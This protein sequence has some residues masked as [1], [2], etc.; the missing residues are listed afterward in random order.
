MKT[1]MC[2]LA[3][4]L[5]FTVQAVF[6]QSLD[7]AK[8]DLYYQHYNTAKQSLTQLASSKPSGEV[9]YYLG[10][11]EIGLEDYQAAKAS[12]QKGIQTDPQSALNY[13]G[14]GRVS[15]S[16]DKDFTAAK[17]SF[18]KAWD[19]SE[20]RDFNVVRGILNATALSP[21]ADGQ[22]AIDLV[23]QF[24]DNRKNRKYE[25]TAPDYTAMGNVY[26]NLPDGGGKAATNYETAE[27]TDP[28]FAEAFYQE[29]NLW[30]R[31][32]QDSLA[33]QFWNGAISADQNYSPALYALYSYYRVRDLTKAQDYLNKYMALSDDKLNA[34]VNLVDVL[35]LQKEYQKAIDQANQLNTQPINPDTKTRLYKLIA[36]SQLA[37]GDSLDAKKNMDTYFQKQDT[38]KVLPKDY[39]F[40]ADVLKKLNE[41]SLSLVYLNKYVDKDTSTNLEFI[42]QEA[43]SLRESNDFKAADLW[44]NKLFSTA[45]TTQ[46][47]MADY[48]YRAFSKYGAATKGMGSWDDA[49]TYWKKFTTKYPDQPS[50]YYYIAQC[51]QAQ[52]TAYTGLAIDT[53]NKYISK[54]K[55]DELK[56]KADILTR[57]YS[58]MAGCYETQGDDAKALEYA[59]KLIAMDPHSAVASN[60]NSSIAYKALKAKDLDKA[61]DYAQ[62][63]LA[64][65]P[66]N[67]VAPQVLDY[68]KQMK[69]YQEKM[70]KYNEANKKKADN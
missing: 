16:S 12:F 48:Y 58:Y 18:Q 66:Q 68:V 46:L 53:Y 54:L 61:T 11:A 35:Y 14:L 43:N 22:Y 20:G 23:T 17:Q 52:D 51:Q 21:K 1:K 65:N 28:K 8:K 32:R 25:L 49:I 26:A 67:T 56:S 33:L 27:S 40:Y 29:G 45:D 19:L 37:L 3:A 41:D 34:Q 36:Y 69:Q 70:K 50:G 13:V 44:F 6:S 39:Q 62:K 57:I 10:L 30:D 63:A 60:V 9:Y 24:K 4:L 47:T 31:A 38:D 64:I 42:R 2:M 5:L 59:G 7:D 55:P 15:I